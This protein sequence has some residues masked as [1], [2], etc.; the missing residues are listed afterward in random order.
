[1]NRIARHHSIRGDRALPAAG[2]LEQCM[3]NSSLGLFLC[4]IP[5]LG[6]T[7]ACGS[8]PAGGEGH[9]RFAAVTA[10]SP[11][12][13]SQPAS[14]GAAPVYALVELTETPTAK[15][16]GYAFAR[17]STPAEA[18][19]AAVEQ[20][21][22][23]RTE[24]AT[25]A[26]R[27]AS[28]R[29]PGTS[30]L[31]RL[32]RVLNGIAYVTDAGGA[33]KLG[34]VAGVRAVHIITPL[35]ID[36]ARGT[37]VIGANQLWS[38]TLGFRGENIRVGVIDTGIDYT[39]ANFG[40]PGTATEYLAV[41]PSADPPARLFPNAKVVGG[42]DFAG[43][44]YDASEIATAFPAEDPN[45]MD[46]PEDPD[47]HGG[48]H[49]SHV[50]GTIAGY[51]VTG[52]GAP[53]GGPYTEALDTAAMAIGPGVAPLAKLY[54][55]K[56][57][58]DH[59]GSTALAP[60]AMEWAADPNG[61]G[62]F[63]DHLDVVNLSL[64]SSFGTSAAGDEIIYTNAVNAGVSVV[65]SAGNSGDYY[66]I[67]G[68]PGSTPAV[69]SVAASS[70]GYYPAS[71][72]IT[73]PAALAGFLPAGT[74]AFGPET[75]SAV[76]A[77]LV[78]AVPADAC[79]AIT[80]DLTGKIA[81]IARGTCS[82]A[83][84]TY[85]AQQAGAVAVII[86]NNVAG[87][88]LG[89]AKAETAG[90]IT[91]PALS[92]MKSDGDAIREV[93]TAGTA[94]TATVASG[95]STYLPALGDAIASFSSR[96][97]SRAK[98]RLILKP[99]V[100]APGVNVV[101][102]AVGSGSRGTDMSGTSMAAPIAAGTVALLRQAHPEWTPAAIKA[103]LMNTAGHDL[104]S[105][106]NSP[107][108]RVGEGRTGAG[109]I[110]AARAIASDVIAFDQAAPER[111]SVSF[112]TLDVAA[113][114][115]ERRAVQLSNMGTTP[116]TYDVSIVK[117]ITPPGTDV[118]ASAQTVTVDSG[119]TA[120]V[121]L[122][123]SAEPSQM[124]R[125]RDPSV[126]TTSPAAGAPRH[127]L[128]EVS[129]YLL[130]TPRNGGISLRVP[131][132]AAPVP[133]SSMVAAASLD[134]SAGTTGISNVT[135]QGTGVNTRGSATISG[136]VGV[137]SLVTP[138]ELAYAGEADG[139]SGG[140][141]SP[142]Y[143]PANLANATIKYVGVTS[144]SL[145]NSES[146]ADTELFFAVNT[147]GRWGTPTAS[148][149]EVD[150]WIKQAGAPTW[151]Y[152]LYNTDLG[153]SSA[154][155]GTDVPASALVNLGSK[156]SRPEDYL[157][158]LSASA[159]QP[160]LPSF[161]TDTMVLPVRATSLGLD[162]AGSKAIEFQVVTSNRLGFEVD[163]TPILRYDVANPGLASHVDPSLADMG[164]TGANAPFW[165]DQPGAV[166]PI[167]YDLAN[168]RANGTGSLLLVHHHNAFGSRAE[169]VSVDGLTCGMNDVTCSDEAAP[170]CDP[171][172]GACVGCLTNADCTAWG[173]GA[174][175]DVYGTRTCLSPDCRRAGA[176]ACGAHQTC[177]AELGTCAPNQQ[178]VR[179]MPSPANSTCAAGGQAIMTGY[180]DDRSG[181]LDAE[182]VLT[183]SYVCNGLSAAVTTEA[184]GA[185]CT[186]GGVRVQLL[187]GPAT[188]VCNGAAGADG[189]SAA[190]TPEAAGASCAAGGVKVQVGAGP[191]N[192][193][194]NGA[195]GA[196]GQSA[197]VTPEAAGASCAAGGVKVQVGAGPANYVCNGAAGA[198]GQSAAVTP[199]AAGAQCAT[200]G[201]KIQVGGGTP[202][203]VC[204][205]EAGESATVT[206]EP[207][208]D[209]CANGG[210][211][212]QVGNGAL[213]Y[214][215][216]G[217]AGPAGPTGPAGPK[218]CSSVGG[219]STIFSLLGLAALRR[220]RGDGPSAR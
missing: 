194:C 119:K 54:A 161:L 180:D 16:Y 100:T 64:G 128:S 213:S 21:R 73:A 127:W 79:S 117:G 154:N 173:A 131:Y 88:P 19:S 45:P 77:D 170:V 41:D 198:D 102:T 174:Y 209:N 3:K 27:I 5:L 32:Q 164:V 74:A 85:A 158:G 138:F 112:A 47:G 144:N 152:V 157:N 202:A 197:A 35:E 146:W 53:F 147:Y 156:K 37:S 24:Q 42:W 189:Q 11:Q 49:G 217:A 204:R 186:Y 220:R 76:T 216:N 184:E 122:V 101:S 69:I 141:F 44:T 208:G 4:S 149:V 57:F 203:Y 123:L 50:A 163:R 30:E 166:L 151:E 12:P 129:G 92:I 176:P 145:D 18:T 83:P 38:A 116:V 125:R 86:T 36:N 2:A 160:W 89:M 153:R 179:V 169:A 201:L 167:T 118:T 97:P 219:S 67:T 104:Y 10:P 93:L 80:N 193:V 7:A 96:G 172:S 1:L 195:A 68:A 143:D 20:L 78:A 15:K 105:L 48:G 22:A 165:S 183:T 58:G 63:D 124:V 107:R 187:T 212:V 126:P 114:V 33:A 98:D 168:A 205:G 150:V 95:T 52:V 43:P 218:G 137:Y 178:L 136:D 31:Y 132:Y 13:Q 207:A 87:D 72:Q 14:R 139:R 190:V 140:P 81:L 133:A 91:I 121:D 188:Y 17:G 110:D 55:L 210:L 175:C 148:D 56:V 66:F 8:R 185:H 60:L 34:K 23:V 99:D 59:G 46:G 130:L 211:K 155:P 142:T 134:T 196:D 61:D 51:G 82:F 120:T 40:G 182:E 191:A 9:A 214:V 6:L 84:K 199:E 108:I 192:Y 177:S 65:A 29:I 215:C 39:H 159:E 171:A 75:W 162:T 115:T 71:V 111:V 28:A 103:L 62:E 26:Q 113:A 206:P 109:R 25:L 94:V 135:L 181:V 90:A 200:G 70:V 106:P